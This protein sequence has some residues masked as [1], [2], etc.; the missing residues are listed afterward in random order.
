MSLSPP[1]PKLH[2]RYEIRSRLGQSRLAVVY[3]AYDDRLQRPV[4]VHLLREELMSQPTLMERFL[5]EA[6]RGAQRSHAGLLEVY[7]SGDV[8]G[9]PYMVT[10]DISGVALAE[11][12]PLPLADALGVLRTVA[13]AVALAQSQGA[14]HPPVSSSNVWLLDGGR[15][16]LLENWALTPQQ[17]ALD[18][19]HYRA[20]ERASGAPPSPATTVYSLGILSWETIAGR[21]PFTGP[22]PEAIADQQTRETLPSISAINPR[23]FA[24]GLDNVI[25]GATALDPARRY[26]APVD[27]SRALD[28]YVDQATAQTGRLAILPKLQPAPGAGSGGVFRRRG[29]TA[30]GPVVQPPPPPPVIRQQPRIARRAVAPPLAQPV[31]VAPPPVEPVAQAAPLD[32]Q[33][34]AEQAQRAARRQTRRRSCQR[35]IVKRSIQLALIVAVI[36]GALVGIDYGVAYV[37][38]RAS[39]LNPTAWITSRLPELPDLPDLSWLRG[40]IGQNTGAQPTLVVT[41]PVNLR[42]GPRIGAGF[43]RQLPAGTVLR[44]LEGP[45]AEAGTDRQWIKVSVVS[46]NQEGWV[47]NQ[48]DRLRQQ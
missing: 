31:A 7:D 35:A 38:G 18:L 9:R 22:T 1:P 16:V 43:L 3:R 11:R 26:P 37:S 8:S 27:F 34:V 5:E 23:L 15:A 32:Q 33:S 42:D 41:Q 47:A 24:P 4:V 20:P 46:E 25:Q 40:L 14:P 48:P 28:L 19:A 13:A 39:Q 36:Y 6:R 12:V 2:D 21:R 44:Q 45:V 30:T 17:A 29:D 10:E